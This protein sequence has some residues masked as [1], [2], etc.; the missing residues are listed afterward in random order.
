MN[1][2]IT[3]KEYIKTLHLGR[4]QLDGQAMCANKWTFLYVHFDAG[5][6]RNCYNVPPRV[7]TLDDINKYGTDIF[8]NH[9]YEIERRE[10]KLKNIKHSDCNNCWNCE[11]RGVK[12]QRKPEPFYEAHRIRFN[13]PRDTTALPSFL[14]LYFNNICDLKCV[15]CND[16]SSSQ[17]GAE[18]KKYNEPS[19]SYRDTTGGQLKKIFYEWFEKEGSK[20]LL[21][22]NILGG[23]PLIQNDFYEFADYLLKILKKSPNRYNIKPELSLFTNGNTP[24]KYLERWFALLNELE[25]YIT[26]RIDFS[27]ESVGSRSEFIRSN[28]NWKIFEKNINST[29]EFSK[30]KD[31]RIRFACTHSIMSIPNFIEFLKWARE[32]EKRH[33]VNLSFGTNGV[34]QPAYLSTWNL[35]EDFKP[36][37]DQSVTWIKENAPHWNDQ[38]EYL[39]SVKE[40]LGKYNLKDLKSIPSF[41]EKMMIRRNLDFLQTFP[42]LQNWYK[43]CR[44]ISIDKN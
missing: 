41:V 8:F 17:W 33:D 37:I 9:P 11:D 20:E 18:L 35:T 21:T 26:V 27:N 2:I 13:A 24:K 3:I 12:S 25:K 30:G 36:Y 28:L 7:V 44:E 6:V 22:Y 32:I 43:F 14:E 34:V 38:A 10:E 19:L 1:K 23:E 4:P 39:L 15:Y 42:E 5:I 40:G 16:L 29:I 31:I